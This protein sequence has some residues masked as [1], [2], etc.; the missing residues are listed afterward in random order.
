V[1]EH[2][3]LRAARAGLKVSIAQ[4]E[5]I[6]AP[7]SFEVR[8]RESVSAAGEDRRIGL[9]WNLPV[10][11]ENDARRFAAGARVELSRAEI[12]MLQAELGAEIRRA[13]LAVRRARILAE[14]AE[15]TAVL[16]T[17]RLGMLQTRLEAGTTTRI[18]LTTATFEQRAAVSEKRVE[19]SRIREA[20][21]SLTRW[22]GSMA[23]SGA[24]DASSDTFDPGEHPVVQ[25]AR[26]RANRAHGEGAVA[27]RRGW[28]WPRFVQVSWYR[29]LNEPDRTLLQ[30][31][32]PLPTPGSSPHAVN[33]ARYERRVE[34]LGAARQQVTAAV[35][36][37]RARVE[38]QTHA[39]A[40]V[41]A[42]GERR[43]EAQTLVVKGEEAGV[44]SDEVAELKRAI[45][46]YDHRRRVAELDLEAASIELRLVVGLP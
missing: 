46:D 18:A 27:N 9:R 12:R 42:D 1:D 38:T 32:I 4:V 31:A 29:E 19:K 41:E 16:E 5:R 14:Y 24:C 37:A 15:G 3:I 10:P 20:E 2:P 45:L 7:G 28:F 13:H 33:A 43:R 40:H 8:A 30:I 34:Q 44:S 35:E 21:L 6:G 36:Q 22:T 26:A 23:S 17:A 25:A 11:G 39:L